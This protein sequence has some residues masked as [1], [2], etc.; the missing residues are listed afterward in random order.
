LSA[1]NATSSSRKAP[2]GAAQPRNAESSSST[3]RRIALDGPSVP[4]DPR[5]N[6]WR[7]DIADI[8][9][10]GRLF[11]PHYA[12]PL[13]RACGMLATPLR[14][15]PADGAE[16]ISELLPGEQFAVLDIAAGWAW[17]YCVA[18]HRVGYVE[19][20]ELT[21]PLA[22]THVVVEAMAPIQ[23]EP[24]PL[25]PALS[26]LPMGSR[27]RGKRQGALL[28]IEGG[29]V[30]ASYLR[31]CG[32][33]DEDPAAVAQRLLNAPWQ[34]GGRTCHGIDGCGLV[35]LALQ[36]CGVPAPHDFD[37]LRQVGEALSDDAPL[38][39]GD[40]VVC[41]NIPGLMIDDQLVIHV[42]ERIGRV[43]IEPLHCMDAT[44]ERRR[45]VG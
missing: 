20:I 2:A 10:A 35:Q 27:L 12:A 38:R 40:L 44:L 45:V 13:L 24:D 19:A 9:I 31:K 7:N 30:P 36:L 41:G 42:S 39:R 3:D 23:P 16:Q 17:G 4:L 15:D 11:A 32:E 33:H 6:A 18:D 8:A 26:F 21:E 22:P 1:S 34:A 43:T 29:F 14:T 37:L 5:I 25:A 28:A